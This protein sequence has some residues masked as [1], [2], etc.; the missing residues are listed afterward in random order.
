MELI[1][2]KARGNVLER[3]I[4]I[5][6]QGSFH[7]IPFALSLA[8]FAHVSWRTTIGI[9]DKSSVREE[10]MLCLRRFREWI[11]ILKDIFG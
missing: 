9:M 6:F 1:G 11:P 8:P 5:Y 10:L 7:G 4:R 3:L 2:E